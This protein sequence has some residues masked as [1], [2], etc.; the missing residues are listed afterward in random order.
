MVIPEPGQ[1]PNSWGPG[2]IPRLSALGHPLRQPEASGHDGL[3]GLTG[4]G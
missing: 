2:I 4:P 1:S 3:Q